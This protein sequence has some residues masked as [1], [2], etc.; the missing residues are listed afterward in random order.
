VKRTNHLRFSTTPMGGGAEAW[1]AEM[2][3]ALCNWLY[4][5]L[6]S[7]DPKVSHAASLLT[8]R[9]SGFL[10]D[11]GQEVRE[12]AVRAIA[13]LTERINDHDWRSKRAAWDTCCKVVSDNGDP[14]GEDPYDGLLP[15]DLG[16]DRPYEG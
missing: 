1:L 8:S 2:R 6:A 12:M 3:P 7:G 13:S 14:G 5:G 15:A 4:R 10:G 11:G 16:T 9:L